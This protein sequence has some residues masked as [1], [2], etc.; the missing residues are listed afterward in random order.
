MR[1]GKMLTSCFDKKLV[2]VVSTT[3]GSGTVTLERRSRKFAVG[4]KQVKIPNVINVYNHYMSGVDIYDKKWKNES[5]AHKSNSW[6]ECVLHLVKEVALLNAHILWGSAHGTKIPSKE[7]H[8]QIADEMI[9]K[10]Q[11]EPPLCFWTRNLPCDKNSVLIPTEKD[12]SGR[13]T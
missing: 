7:F 5:Y 10:K 2:N 8:L 12:L 1:S 11:P 3:R 4:K 9:G 6:T 13:L